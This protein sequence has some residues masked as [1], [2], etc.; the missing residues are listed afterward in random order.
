MIRS[1]SANYVSQI[2]S[3]I[4]NVILMPVY[5]K[6][7]GTEAV[8]LIGFSLT[9]TM[10]FS[11]FDSFFSQNL[12]RQ[13]AL[14]SN[15][16]SKSIARDLLRT[17]EIIS[18]IF[19]IIFIL[20]FFIF[21]HWLSTA[22]FKVLT[23]KIE[24]V[25][26]S[27]KLIGIL[28]G[29]RYFEGL[30]RNCLVGL[31]RIVILSK[32]TIV[33]TT[34]RAVGTIWLLI[35]YSS[36]I[37][38]FFIWQIII[39]SLTIIPLFLITMNYTGGMR[40]TRKFSV[41]SLVKDKSFSTGMLIHSI[42]AVA[43]TQGDKIVL[44]KLLTLTDFG[45]Y[46]IASSVAGVVLM[47]VTP[48]TQTLF[49]RMV[50]EIESGSVKG[51]AFL[52]HY[53]CQFVTIFAGSFSMV[54][55]FYSHSILN[56]WLGPL[57]VTTILPNLVAILVTAN[58]IGGVLWM[59]NILQF[60]H[61]YTNLTIISNITAILL[62]FSLLFL[63]VPEYGSIGAGILLIATNCGLLFISIYVFMFKKFL[64]SER[65]NWLFIDLGLILLV[66]F[67]FVYLST[68]ISLDLIPQLLFLASLFV[69]TILI[70]I[71]AAPKIILTLIN[72]E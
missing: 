7:M 50:I 51:L 66:Q 33:S 27:I 38:H 5:I 1:I 11:L 68:F 18:L 67:I 57:N 64:S 36:D 42:L 4:L 12:I 39:T 43:L 6:Y 46:S 45:Y 37:H 65:N 32:I 71:F 48:V 35:F 2:Y 29:L 60:A 55:V 47:L 54:V 20:L 30:Y 26:I 41:D 44:S 25:V 22:W 59:P 34:V 17:V 31:N 10:V 56:F 69:L 14:C 24:T 21:S 9:L 3:A 53:G 49:G 62:Y 19:I 28:I 15:D 8:G 72:S 40:I 16:N 52:F 63:I 23:T 13:L 61:K 70:S 58:F